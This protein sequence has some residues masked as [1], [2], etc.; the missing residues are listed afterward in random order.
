MSELAER[1]VTLERVYVWEAPVRATHW[2][3]FFS[4]LVLAGTGY[5]IGHPFI[6]VA[7]PAT[8][9]FVMGM[10][11][12]IH[13]YAAIFFTLA[14]VVR[15][16]W[17]FAG[18]RF[19]RLSEFVPVSKQ[20]LLSLWHTFLYYSF[21]RREPD[22]YAGHNALAASSYLMIFA[23]YL[24]MIATGFVLYAANASIGS[25][26]R[27]FEYLAPL[28]G[29]LTIARLLHHIGMWIIL[30]FVVV[31]I[32]FVFLSSLIEHIGTFDSIF[33]GYKFMPTRELDNP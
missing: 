25:P 11:I 32:Y 16:Y 2:V 30:I 27:I 33:S 17:L 13:M 6:D 14:V 23:V 24:L 15:L 19:A 21:I 10:A 20:R 9:H 31:H 29:G 3:L 4:I 8:N 12:A 1:K 28:F 7:G 5:Y 22:H 18:N 26:V